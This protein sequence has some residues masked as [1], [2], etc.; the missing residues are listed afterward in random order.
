MIL[1]PLFV[2]VLYVD[3]RKLNGQVVLERERKVK[4]MKRKF[5]DTVIMLCDYRNTDRF[6]NPR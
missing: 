4:S 2:R 3:V 5:S 6:S 1:F